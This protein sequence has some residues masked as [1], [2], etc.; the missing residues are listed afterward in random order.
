MKRVLIALMLCVVS[1]CGFSQSYAIQEWDYIG[2][3][4]KKTAYDYDMKFN[5]VGYGNLMFHDSITYLNT[6][7]KI[8]FYVWDSYQDGC[9]IYN[10]G[11]IL[12]SLGAA[13]IFI[14][15]VMTMYYY[16][17]MNHFGYSKI[18]P[19]LPASLSVVGDITLGAGVTFMLVGRGD[20]RACNISAYKDYNYINK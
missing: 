12:T 18:H 2:K 13:L 4:I 20:K 14:G 19:A 15:G 11:T 17:H 1:I 5:Q 9:K 8:S 16:S 10:E 7:P 3:R 6:H